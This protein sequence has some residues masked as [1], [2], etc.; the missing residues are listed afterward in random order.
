MTDRIAESVTERL[1][2][3]DA[4]IDRDWQESQPTREELDADNK[5]TRRWL[6]VLAGC[7][8]PVRRGREARA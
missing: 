5:R 4:R 6:L 7:D 8:Q 2:S 3:R 1:A